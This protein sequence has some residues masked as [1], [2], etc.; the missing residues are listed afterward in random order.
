MCKD[1]RVTTL[2]KE[3]IKIDADFPSNMELAR[4]ILDK[5][6]Y[7]PGRDYI[8]LVS[9]YCDQ[10]TEIRYHKSTKEEDRET[11]LC[12]LAKHFSIVMPDR[13]VP[14]PESEID[15]NVIRNV[16]DIKM[17]YNKIQKKSLK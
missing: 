8:H 1:N 12:F 9:Q 6:G 14:L 2:I 13:Y 15:G 5:E 16:E 10:L 17:L 7:V 4:L 11:N 3:G